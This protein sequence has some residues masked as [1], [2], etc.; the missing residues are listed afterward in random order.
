MNKA[1]DV[2]THPSDASSMQYLDTKN[3]DYFNNAPK[4]PQKDLYNMCKKCRN[5]VTIDWNN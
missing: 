2:G 1:V 3:P 5:Y 4:T